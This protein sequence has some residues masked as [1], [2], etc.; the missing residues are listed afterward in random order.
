MDIEE[1]IE[2]LGFY[3]EVVVRALRRHLGGE[4]PLAM[5]SQLDAAFDHD[6]MF[7]HLTC[8]AL[9]P[10]HLLQIHVDELDGGSA[11]VATQMIALSEIRG[12]SVVEVVAD[13]ASTGGT[14]QEV[15]I[16]VNAG[17]QRRADLEPVHCDDPEC[18]A[19]HGYSATSYPDDLSLRIS[20]A[21][22]GEENLERAERFVDVLTAR[23]REL[24]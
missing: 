9:G 18:V 3:P 24:R 17:G 16:A 23:L 13:A 12:V 11:M 7:R 2:R 8:A 1:E 21:A 19:D 5:V 4:E 14:P 20:L 22:N 15:S 10:T 6:T